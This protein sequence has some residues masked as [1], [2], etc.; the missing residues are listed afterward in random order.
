MIGNPSYYRDADGDKEFGDEESSHPECIELTCA[1]CGMI[2]LAN[3]FPMV[4][5]INPEINDLITDP[6]SKELLFSD[7]EHR[8]YDQDSIQREI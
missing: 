8:V 5:I 2:V 6:N 1:H 3:T 4:P 7:V